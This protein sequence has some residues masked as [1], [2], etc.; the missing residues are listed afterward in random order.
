[1]AGAMAGMFLAENGATVVKVEPPGG[2]PY[3]DDPSFRVWDRGKESVVA[4]L[5]APAG[6]AALHELLAWADGS[7]DDLR[8]GVADRLGLGWDTVHAA[9]PHLVSVTI[10]GFGE[11]GPFR[12]LPG[13]EQLVSA[14]TGRMATLNGYRDGPIFTPAPIAC[15]GAANLAAQGLLAAVRARG[16][17]GHGR[18]VTTSLLHALVA[19][20]MTS[21][22]GHRI[23]TP[24]EGGKAYGVLPLGFMTAETK[25]G[26]FLQMCSRAPHL[27][28]NWMRAIGMEYLYDDPA[29]T[30][31]PDVLPSWDALW[32]V[33][34]EAMAKMRERTAAEWFEIFE[35]EDV[36]CDPFFSPTEFLHCEQA[37][38]TGRVQTVVDPEV[39]ATTQIGPLAN[40]S[41]TPAVIG[42]PAPRLGAH[43]ETALARARQTPKPRPSAVATNKLP[44]EGITVLEAA[45]F[46]AAPFAMTLLAQMGARV[47]KIEPPT[48]DASRR[49]FA[50]YYTKEGTGKE[51][52]IADLKT[53]EGRE[54]VYELARRSDLFLHNFRK[55]VPERLG[56]D[57]DTMHQINPRLLYIYQGAFGSTGP[58]AA[59]PGYH[60]SPNAIAGV[61]VVEGGRGNPPINRT[62]G[63]PAGALG[64]ATAAL[65]GLSARERTGEGQYLET[66]MLSSLAYAVS[67]WSIEYDGK[68]EGRA[69]DKGQHGFN[70]LCRLYQADEGWLFLMCPREREWR[71]LVQAIDAPELASDP[72]FATSDARAA[73][74]DDLAELL[75]GTIAKRSANDWER[76]LQATG[77]PAARADGIDHLDFMLN[78][79]HMKDNGLSIEDELVDGR[80]FWRSTGGVEFSGSEPYVGT[81]NPLGWATDAVLTEIGYDQATIDDLRARGIIL[82]VGD[83]LPRD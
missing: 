53:P 11:R 18:R 21:G 13:Y 69:A 63:D 15:Y 78:H 23:H 16:A 20:D 4:D 76:T 31:M 8:P 26:R 67:G 74:D 22:F 27:F 46:Y 17:T 54:I 64:L 34:D 50:T 47:I 41:A 45:M 62:Y 33:R 58:W 29:Y 80:R 30:E 7:I 1:M 40:M 43:T 51:S 19:Y 61:G 2:V 79:Q 82:A 37:I 44:L 12:D 36:G 77:V 14:V 71:Q 42:A 35:R 68:P 38:A 25:D 49:N 66:T 39:G 32:R 9:H 59:R 65:A 28:R 6:R 81:V 60:S 10:S 70:A 55:G 52:V 57:Y 73:N 48:G 3:R 75:A 56:I 24:Q 83:G 72:R 5:K